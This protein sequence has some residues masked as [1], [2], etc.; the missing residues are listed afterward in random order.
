MASRASFITAKNK[1]LVV[2]QAPPVQPSPTSFAPISHPAG[3]KR[4]R[5]QDSEAKADEPESVRSSKYHQGPSTLEHKA[6]ENLQDSIAE[7]DE[8]EGVSHSEEPQE[9]PPQARPVQS[10]STPPAPFSQPVGTKRKRSQDPKAEVEADELEDV[11]PSKQPQEL[12]PPEHKLSEK[13]LQLHN[14]NMDNAVNSSRA[15][16]IKRS[17]S[18]RSLSRHSNTASDRTQGTKG[19]ASTNA[20]YRF[21]ILHPAL[22][23]VHA[24]P[25]PKDIQDAIDAIIEAKP[26]EGRRKQLEPIFQVFQ[27]RCAEK[28]RASVGENDFVKIFHDALDSMSFNN[29]C[30]R[31][32][33]DW[34]EQL[35]PK[36]QHSRFN[37]AA[38]HSK[39]GCQQQQIDNASAPPPAK[40][41]QQIAGQTYISPEPSMANESDPPPIN[42]LQES[43]KMPPPAPIP[44]REGT[45]KTPRPDIS[46]GIVLRALVSALSSQDLDKVEA[47]L[48]LGD[49]QAEKESYEPDG[50]E[51]PMLISAPASRASDLVFPFAVLEGKAYLTGKQISEAEN[52]AAVSGAC[53]LKMQLRLDE[54][55]KRATAKPSKDQSPASSDGLPAP[56]KGQL[57]TLRPPSENQIPLFFSI[58]TEG[59]IHQLF[60]HWTE[61]NYGKRQFNMRLLKCVHGLLPDGLEDFFVKLDN[62]LRWGT[63]HFLESL[64][65]RLGKVARNTG[66]YA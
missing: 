48:F 62:V 3:T 57:R 11:R 53:A 63:E 23:N 26:P 50:L 18:Q 60:V 65:V 64:V 10:S 13:N 4:E 36:I 41:Q 24:D 43:N 9:L 31:T 33:A 19:S 17:S 54:L 15:E 39:A 28:T 45:I 7:A 6:P 20:H 30:L 21:K 1:A 55:A 5:S 66:A 61:V 56:L 14:K 22:I 16:S 51:E 25:P 42:E 49:L 59:P 52:Q 2:S 46:M 40:R 8:P 29:L 38:L 58:C 32:N 44:E 37:V 34:Q 27:A 35:K 12:L 47:E